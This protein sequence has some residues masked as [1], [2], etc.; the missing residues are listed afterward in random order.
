MR[1]CHARQAMLTM[2]SIR[3]FAHLP[4]PS[5]RCRSQSLRRSWSRNSIEIDFLRTNLNNNKCL[6]CTFHISLRWLMPSLLPPVRTSCL[7]MK[8]SISIL[9]TPSVGKP[10]STLWPYCRETWIIFGRN[11]AC[12]YLRTHIKWN[13]IPFPPWAPMRCALDRQINGSNAK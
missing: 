11:D 3:P 5:H 1:F 6:F 7:P 10:M 4:L 2:Y 9:H 8:M 13:R 12:I